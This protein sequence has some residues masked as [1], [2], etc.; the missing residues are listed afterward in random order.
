[1]SSIRE[2]MKQSLMQRTE[3]SYTRKDSSG[4]FKSIFRDDVPD[5]KMMKVASGENILDIIPYIAGAHDPHV[6]EGEPTY[7][8]EV[9]VH[10]KVGVNEDSY[11]CLARTFNRACPECE[12]QNRLRNEGADKDTLDL[13]KPSRRMLYNVLNYNSRQEEEK[14]V[15]VWEASHWLFERLIVPLAKKPRRA[16]S[17]GG[18]YIA[19][20]DPDEGKSIRFEK[21]GERLSTDYVGHQ[22]LDRDYKIEDAILNAAK[23]LDEIIYIPTYEEVY[24][25]RHGHAPGEE[26]EAQQEQKQ[27]VAKEEAPATTG[28]RTRTPL[29]EPAAEPEKEEPKQE[30]AKEEPAKEAAAETT[31]R[32]TVRNTP[33]AEEGSTEKCP[34]GGV[35][36]VDLDQLKPCEDCPLWEKC[37]AEADKRERAKAGK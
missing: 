7:G 24:T 23:I 19:F 1:M 14:G 4:K 15:Q 3:E 26:G 29:Q 16:G 6:Q 20:S 25:A 32:R 10:N 22:F 17:T 31:S 5:L 30:V 8:L 13:F 2:K 37:A 11:I 21:T 27:E 9:Y 34:S 18:G 33:A 36:G 35:F 28:R 12:E